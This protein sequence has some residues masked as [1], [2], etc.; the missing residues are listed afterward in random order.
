VPCLEAEVAAGHDVRAVLCRADKPAGRGNKLHEP[1]V[2]QAALKHGLRVLQPTK[3]RKNAE[4]QATLKTLELEVVV[5]VAYG[6]LVPTWLLELA[7]AG[8][9]NVHGSIL[10]LLRGAAPIQ[11]A[12]LE[13]FASSGISLMKL[14][15]G[16][17]TG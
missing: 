1:P 6:M 11:H 4:L 9:V 10:P 13:G 8:C 15:E 16:M 12:I 3:L 17:D 5:V 7:P 2:K 14:D